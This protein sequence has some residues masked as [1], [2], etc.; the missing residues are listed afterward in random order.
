MKSRRSIF[1]RAF[2]LFLVVS[3]LI[4]SFAIAAPPEAYA[5]YV[6]EVEVT[7]PVEVDPVVPDP[8]VQSPGEDE[9]DGP[10]V[11]LP[12]E[13]E[14]DG[15]PVQL[16]DDDDDDDPPFLLPGDDD[17]PP[18]Q[19]PGEDDGDDESEDDIED[20]EYVVIDL[21]GGKFVVSAEAIAA[22]AGAVQFI[23][24]NQWIQI[25]SAWH[26]S[27]SFT[28][29]GFYLIRSGGQYFPVYCLQPRI[30]A[31]PTGNYTY[32]VLESNTLLARGL[33]Y[34]F[35][36][37]GQQYYLDN[38]TGI[39]LVNSAHTGS[40]R[41][42]TL[43]LLSFMTL[44][45]IYQGQF[46]ARLTGVNQAGRN[47]AFAFRNWI[48]AAPAPPD[49]RLSFS[50]PNAVANV[51]L[52]SGYQ[53]TP[54]IRLNADPRNS[55]T[56][57]PRAFGN[58]VSLHRIR[59]GQTTVHWSDVEIRG[60]DAFRLRAPADIEPGTVSSGDLYGSQDMRWFALM[61][62][63]AASTQTM[64]GWSR[65]FDPAP[66]IRLSVRWADITGG[67]IVHKFSESGR[68][69]GVDFRIQGVDENN[70]YIDR[71]ITTYG[72][73][74]TYGDGYAVVT[75]LLP[76]RYRVT[77]INIPGIYIP[78]EPLYINVVLHQLYETRITFRNRVARGRIEGQKVDDTGAP[79]A[80][81]VIGLFPAY[82]DEFTDET[83]IAVDVSGEDGSFRFEHL[84]IMPR[85][86]REIASPA[87]FRLND[88]IFPVDIMYHGQ[89]IELTIVNEPTQVTIRTQAHTGDG[90]NQ[91]FYHGD[92][93]RMFD[94]VEITHEG[95]LDGTERAFETF[96]VARLPDGTV[97]DVWRSGLIDY[98]VYDMVFAHRVVTEYVDTGRFL[99][100]TIFT[101]REVGFNK[102][103]EADVWYN[104]DFEDKNQNLYPRP[105]VTIRTQAHTGDG[106][107]QYF[108]HG[109]VLRMFDD[110]EITHEGILDGTERAFETFLVARLPDG[111][112]QDVWRSGLIDYVVEDAVFAHR[113]VTEY[114]DT[115]RF[116]F[117]TIFTF[118]E[119]GFNEDGEADVWY[120][121]DFEDKNQNLYMRRRSDVPRTGDETVLPWIQLVGLVSLLVLIVGG[122][123]WHFVCSR[124]KRKVQGE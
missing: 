51:N 27:G 100:G 89:V 81:A 123:S 38:L 68:V 104:C 35:G 25:P 73:G 66:P 36:A 58:Y 103:G 46:P 61:F 28:N 101:F 30:P 108:Y 113:V 10:P 63:Q 17:D 11:Q 120:N 69:I 21:D 97:Q 107:N 102:D 44:S 37:P 76:G 47:A 70:G 22:S 52:A 55:I 119:V 64:G 20:D 71:E 124:R 96:L 50:V 111:T 83:A 80:G 19:L 74:Q 14:D 9:D 31:P 45:T 87:G 88:E 33:Y 90:S 43:Y 24:R 39:P 42:D 115:G 59:D 2:S 98:V 114:V 117:G 91:Y 23:N 48:Q 49:S 13:D 94:D 86:I 109:D 82:V 93:L 62:N 95:I 40:R 53:Y 34:V 56:M 12:G 15:P 112:V 77:E 60:G 118:R 4:G 79:L 106:S 122:V 5:E 8:P 26:H 110:V 6:Q 78:V 105:R 67:M 99:F 32:T 116:P 41:G 65:Y 16:P 121:C 92:V 7:Q 57:D 85:V 75:D 54:E 18:V 29:V 72:M 3:L 84:H 1:I